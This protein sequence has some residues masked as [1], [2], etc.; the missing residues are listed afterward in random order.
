MHEE[1]ENYGLPK[2]RKGDPERDPEN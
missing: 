2:H 1:T